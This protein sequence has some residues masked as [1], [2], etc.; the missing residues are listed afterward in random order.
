MRVRRRTGVLGVVVIDQ[1][2]CLADRVQHL[3]GADDDAA[4]RVAAH[5][6]LARVSESG[7]PCG[8]EHVRWQPAAADGIPGEC[9]G[10]MT[11]PVERGVQGGGVRHLG[12]DDVVGEGMQREGTG[13]SAR[14]LPAGSPAAPG[15]AIAVGVPEAMA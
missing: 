10:E 5:H 6:S 4:E 1:A 9:A 14:S 15:A 2:Q 12:L 3:D 11:V 8:P 7:L 13:G